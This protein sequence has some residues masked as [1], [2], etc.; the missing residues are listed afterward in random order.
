ML[1]GTA[2]PFL[3]LLLLALL[4]CF[5]LLVGALL[6]PLGIAFH[7]GTQAVCLAHCKCIAPLP[8]LLCNKQS[9]ASSS[10]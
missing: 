2:A 4:L 9:W 10:L 3:V 5:G 1:R 7:L 6:R 8:L